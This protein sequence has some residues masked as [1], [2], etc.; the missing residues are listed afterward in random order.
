[1]Q[2]FI[3][4]VFA[5]PV[6]CMY[7]H[8]GTFTYEINFGRRDAVSLM[9]FHGVVFA[10]FHTSVIRLRNICNTCNQ[11]KDVTKDVLSHLEVQ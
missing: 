2:R 4:P 6:M 1:M 9:L 11:T 3:I 8:A 5:Y 7:V 10:D